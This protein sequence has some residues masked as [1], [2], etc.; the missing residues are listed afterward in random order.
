MR[1]RSARSLTLI[2]A[3]WK[4]GRAGEMAEARTVASMNDDTSSVRPSTSLAATE[5][6]VMGRPRVD[7]E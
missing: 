2:N 6:C 4:Q 1:L 5:D 3:K 7:V